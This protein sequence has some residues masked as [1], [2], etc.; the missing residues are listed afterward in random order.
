MAMTTATAW[1]VLLLAGL[2]EM[3]WALGLKLA[4]G[5]GRAHAWG[6]AVAVACLAFSMFLLYQAQRVIP[7]GVAY[8]VWTGI[9]AAGTFL[10]GVWLFGDAAGPMKYLGVA[11]IV[12]GIALLKWGA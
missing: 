7:I 2:F 6:L 11:L 10:L 1:I 12:G 8:A 4:Q 9:G 5:D 3:G